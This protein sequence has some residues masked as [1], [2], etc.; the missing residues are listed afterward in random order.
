MNV[1]IY[2]LR[3]T[4]MAVLPITLI[5]LFLHITI[6]PLTSSLIIPFLLG[7]VLIVLGLSLFLIGVDLGITP[8]GEITG[9][10]IAKTNKLWIVL[11]AGFILGFFISVA[12][13]GLLVFATQVEYVTSGQIGAVGMLLVV[14]IGLAFLV[15]LGLIRILYNL[16]LY[17]I[18]TVLYALIFVLALFASPEH[19]AIAFDAS[20]ATT[21]I[22]AVPFILA[23]SVG[24]SVM[25]KDSK[26]SEKDSFGLIAI[27]S[28]GAIL[29]VLALNVF[30]NN[31]AA[32]VGP[33]ILEATVETVS[34]QT[35]IV[36]ILGES[37]L[38]LI[39][40]LIIFLVLQK[41]SFRL[42]R[43]A[44]NRVLKGF[45]YALLGLFLF[46]LGAN[47]GFM[48][49]GTELGL[50]LAV[51]HNSYLIVL[52][53]FALGVVTILA[54]P[55]VYVLTHQIE[56][57]TAGYVKRQSVLVALSIGVGLA[58]ALSVLRVLV[59]S[60]QL[61]HYLLPGY[62]ICIALSYFVPKLFIGIAFDAGGVATGPM[63]AT[64]ILAFT[65]GAAEAFDGANVLIDGFGMIAMVAM[66]PIITL[67][68][69]GL[70]FKMKTRKE[71]I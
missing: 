56:N 46:L 26:S 68:I 58:V 63:T 59:P 61:W 64:F 39:P 32:E 71:G 43:R 2:R 45:I 16:P 31:R 30:S 60:I 23:L 7:S 28:I 51:H 14:S 54:E 19:L 36:D 53:G 13:P 57:V 3:E 34:V 21:G 37:I 62:I 24:I 25:K 27:A 9:D 55:A 40:L 22:L 8:L 65:N 12:E 47:A 20:G 41:V 10:A 18:L 17:L 5:V 48:N 70:L 67:Q 15:V 6:V 49:V 4:V 29:S 66:T 50:H 44:F 42:S 1:L 52:V 35:M 38:A 11:L 69:L 33:D